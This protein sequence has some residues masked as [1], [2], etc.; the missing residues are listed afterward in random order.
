MNQFSGTNNSFPFLIF[1]ILEDAKTIDK[2][3][4]PMKAKAKPGSKA[5]G[6]DNHKARWKAS[7]Q[8]SHVSFC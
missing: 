2:A 7:S 3:N 5:N 8:Q 6:I 1:G 4:E